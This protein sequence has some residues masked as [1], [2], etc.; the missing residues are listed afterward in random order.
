[1][2][3]NIKSP[4]EALLVWINNDL[5]PEVEQDVFNNYYKGYIKEFP[6]RIQYFYD[7]QLEDA[8]KILSNIDNPSVLEIGSGLGSESLFLAYKGANVLGIDIKDDR[9]NTA[10]KRKEIMENSLNKKLTCNFKNM[11][12]L[13]LSEEEKYDLIWLEQ[14]YHHLEPR[15][16]VSEKISRLLKPN[17]YLIVSEANAQNILI[18]AFLFKQRGFRT[19]NYYEDS[20]GQK[21]VYGNERILTA[22]SLSKVFKKYNINKVDVNYFRIF[23]NKKVFDNYFELE[24]KFP[25]VLSPFFTHYNYI[26]KKSEK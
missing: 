24:K 9:V 21:H 3:N 6:K 4:S 14:A 17:G 12:V 1:M 2:F 7:K 13:D 19:I 5:L 8:L 22:N 20:A 25:K 26:G 18:Q 23:P 15:E 11:S 16:I 10:I